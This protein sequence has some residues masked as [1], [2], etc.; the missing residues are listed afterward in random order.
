MDFTSKALSDVSSFIENEKDYKRRDLVSKWLS[1]YI[2]FLNTEKSFQPEKLKR[3][4]RG[5]IIMVDFGYRIGNELGGPHYAVVLDKHNDLHSG[6]ITVLPLS[7]KK[8]NTKINRFKLDLGNEIY[9]SLT[10]K[11]D[12]KFNET[13]VI[14]ELPSERHGNVY[15]AGVKFSFSNDQYKKIKKEIDLMKEGSIALMTQI[16]SISK[17]RI[18]KPRRT[19]DP[20]SG[21]RLK[22]E[23]LDKID[24]KILELYTGASLNNS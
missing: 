24:K 20:L 10:E 19:T 13:L 17:M 6:T 4:L 11:A 8:S 15:T 14:T 22:D 7:S 9:E 21:I 2:S 18:I 5:E 23:T 3:Y 12:R 1:K 16:T